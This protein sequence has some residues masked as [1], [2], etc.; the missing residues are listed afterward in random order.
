MTHAAVAQDLLAALAAFAPVGHYIEG[1]DGGE[2]L[3]RERIVASDALQ[4]GDEDARV[5]PGP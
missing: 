4:L 2:L 1:E 5:R 3:D